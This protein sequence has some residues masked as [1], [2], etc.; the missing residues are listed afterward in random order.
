MVA[1]LVTSFS[2]TTDP[3]AMHVSLRR[4]TEMVANMRLDRSTILFRFL[5]PR[6]RPGRRPS[7]HSTRTAR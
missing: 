5:G 1:A 4:S 2:T 7:Y 6:S 3:E